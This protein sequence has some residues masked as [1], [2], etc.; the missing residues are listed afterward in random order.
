M[1]ADIPKACYAAMC[2][3]FDTQIKAVY[4]TMG[5]NLPGALKPVT[6][7]NRVDIKING[8]RIRL[9]KPVRYLYDIALIV[10]TDA[11]N[12]LYY[13]Q[14]VVGAIAARLTDIPVVL[15]GTHIGCMSL[16]PD[17]TDMIIFTPGSI[18]PAEPVDRKYITATYQFE[19]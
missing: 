5:V 9:I 15:D 16:Q 11:S 6:D 3:F 2:K 12:N 8:P 19:E 17:E 10:I 14:E 4:S 18:S 7:R 13:G 1:N